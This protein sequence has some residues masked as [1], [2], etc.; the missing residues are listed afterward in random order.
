MKSAAAQRITVETFRQMKQEGR[1]ITMATAYDAITGRWADA[2]GIDTVLVGDSLGNTALG[3]EDTIAV[4]L[5]M[6]IHHCAAVA[7]GVRR[8]F[9]VGD[10][11]FMTYK[12]SPEQAM[13]SAGR[14]MQEGRVKAVKLEGGHEVVPAIERMTAAGIPVLGHLGL[15]PQSYHALGGYKLQGKGNAAARRLIEDAQALQAAGV[16]GVVL[17]KIPAPLAAG[18]SAALEVPT[19]GIGAGAGCD[20]QVLVLA[21]LLGM[22]EMAP[23][24]F[25]K[26]YGNLGTAAIEALRAFGEDVRAGRFPGK[27]QSYDA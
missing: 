13:E 21:D 11:P 18:V 7:R 26:Q 5:P 9:L 2:S 17:E 15:L 22:T 14:L 3:F 24:K 16:F 25:V 4:T 12:T 10:L 6:M 1:R 23:L 27:E 20:G 19:I 8:A